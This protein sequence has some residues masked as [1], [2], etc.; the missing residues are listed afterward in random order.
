MNIHRFDTKE[1]ASMAAAK[2][3]AALIQ[4]Q[5]NVT[6]G[7]ATGSTPI[8]FYKYLHQLGPVMDQVQS[9]NLDEYVGLAS[10]HPA[11]FYQY[12][13][14]H[15][16]IP[17]QLRPSQLH[18]PSGD[19]SP[20]QSLQEYRHAL[21]GVTIDLQL[22][23]IGTNGH[24]GFNE[25]GCDF[26]NDVHIETLDATTKNANQASFGSADLVPDLAITMGIKSILSA[27]QIVLLAFG[28]AKADAVAQM[29]QGPVTNEWPASV[30]QQH[31][32]VHVYLDHAA[33]AKLT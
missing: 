23:G 20:D 1:A 19:L 10:H 8:L 17:F 22:L 29:I 33:A 7:L 6:L 5:P 16:V 18:R 24:I 25:P 14:T 12:M 32:N 27:K 21:K 13:Q 2:R 4:Q 3:V 9:Y 31:Q 30:L 11:S 15:F 26:D 28:D